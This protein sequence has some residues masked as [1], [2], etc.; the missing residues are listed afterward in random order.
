M[1]YTRPPGKIKLLAGTVLAMSAS[2][3]AAV[4]AWS[5]QEPQLR[6]LSAGTPQLELATLAAD[7]AA[8]RPAILERTAIATAPSLASVAARHAPDAHIRL[9]PPAPSAANRAPDRAATDSTTP[10]DA[11]DPQPAP[12]A[13]PQA[14]SETEATVDVEPARLVEASRPSFPTTFNKPELVSY[15]GMPESELPGPD[16]KPEGNLW[17]M[18]VR[19]M[20]DE[21]GKPTKASVTDNDLSSD[22]MVR[23]FERLA[24]RAVRDWR[25]EPARIDGE[26]V[27]S[28]MRMAFHFDTRIGRPHDIGDP[29]YAVIRP[30]RMRQRTWN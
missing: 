13:D 24:L 6:Y 5:S 30:I 17:R 4:G 23:R 21:Q 8:P 10:A 16:W 20:L 19:V 18:E 28:E 26:P 25:Y 1:L 9:A 12:A 11:P 22:G 15:P 7:P 14:T 27:A 29:P 3:A 2:T